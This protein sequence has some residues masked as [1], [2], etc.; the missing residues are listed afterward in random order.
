LN[1]FFPAPIMSASDVRA[2]ALALINAIPQ[3]TPTTRGDWGPLPHAPGDPT[4][5]ATPPSPLLSQVLAASWADSTLKNY[6]RGIAAF[7]AWCDTKGVA[8]HLRLP[9]SEALLCEFAAS[10]A[11]IHSGSSAR[12]ALAGLRAL[13]LLLGVPYQGGTRLAQALKGVENLRPP[14]SRRP[15]RPPVTVHLLDILALNLC[16]TSPLDVACLAVATSAFWSQARLGELLP[17]SHFVH[18]P[19]KL[20]SRSD[21]GA[22][23]TARGSRSLHLPWSKTTRSAGASIVICRQ[24][25]LSDPIAA[26]EAHLALNDPPPHLPLFAFSADGRFAALTKRKFLA[27]CNAAWGPLV[28]HDLTGHCF[29]IGGTTELL[30]RGTPPHVVKALGRWSSDAF[31]RYWRST[32]ALA[33]IHVEDS[34]APS[35]S[36]A[37]HPLAA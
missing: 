31:L 24:Q 11:G 18:D 1:D 8:A 17:V 27:R 25:G 35:S 26:L 28:A 6:N 14:N 12:N 33:H 4:N 34:L 7:S 19:S 21:L 29:R 5:V 9:A 10:S 30:L 3:P 20:P 15:P 2:I 13:H 36:S 16:P 37:P 22:P 32:D 23:A